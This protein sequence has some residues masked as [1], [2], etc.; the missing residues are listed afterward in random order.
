MSRPSRP[1]RGLEPGGPNSDPHRF[2]GDRGV[3]N[4]GNRDQ[5]RDPGGAD[6]ASAAEEA[7]SG[8]GT[9][10]DGRVW[11]TSQQAPR[12]Q[13][14]GRYVPESVAHPAKML[15]AIAAHAIATYTQPGQLVLDPMCGIG[16][17]LV[18]AVR[19]GR[20]AVGVEYEHRW[21]QLATTNLALAAADGH[22]S[23]ATVL[24]GDARQLRSLLP[25]SL[26]GKVALIITSPPYGPSTHGHV[27][28]DD[29][30]KIVKVNHRY[31]SLLDRGNLANVGHHR[32]LVGFTRILA[33]A[34]TFLRP[35][36][37]VV[38]TVRPWREHAELIDLPAQI[39]ACGE[40]A[41]LIPVDRCVALLGRVDRR[42]Q[43]VA[44]GSF[45]QRDFIAKQR[46]L[47]LPLHL[48]AHEDV[49]I[50]QREQT[51]VGSP[52]LHGTQREH[53]RAVR[54]ASHVDPRVGDAEAA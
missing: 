49:V 23:P 54:T 45:F 33:A 8:I 10:A 19:A 38:I 11:L 46:R 39:I 40:A 44:R 12:T 53:L 9:G 18:E 52:E 7:G 24:R 14:A 2:N 31:G 21:A 26:A 16:T 17:T 22:T 35:G 15:P 20:A 43:F 37:H 51:S 32:L 13:R 1:R 36:G 29:N 47:G 5:V 41:G 25:R 50:L 27:T 3:A 42:G 48:I 4:D 28:H 6:A 30:N 34:T